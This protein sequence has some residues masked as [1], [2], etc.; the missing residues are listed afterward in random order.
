MTKKYGDY[1]AGPQEA[2]PLVWEHLAEPEQ[3]LLENVHA[4]LN[5]ICD[6]APPQ[7]DPRSPEPWAEIDQDPRG[8]VMFINGGR[9][10]GKTTLLVTLLD[11]LSRARQKNGEQDPVT[12]G[13]A[14]RVRPL[15]ILDFDPLPEGLPLHAWLVQAWLPLVKYLEGCTRKKSPQARD[16]ICLEAAILQEE[17]DKLFE[18]AVFGWAD[19]HDGRPVVERLFDHRDQLSGYQALADDW[20]VFVD[21]VFERLVKAGDP[22][23]AVILVPIDDVDLQVG[24]NTELIHATRLLRH[25]RVVYLIT[26]DLEHTRDVVLLDYRRQHRKVAGL[27]GSSGMPPEDQLLLGKC[28]DLADALMEKAFPET[29]VFA[30]APVSIETLLTLNG[31]E[32]Q[33]V[34]DELT[35]GDQPVGQW[36]LSRSTVKTGSNEAFMQWRGVQRMFDRLLQIDSTKEK[37]AYVLK[38]ILAQGDAA[39]SVTTISDQPHGA[40]VDFGLAGELRVSGVPGWHAGIRNQRIVV[41][42]KLKTPTQFVTLDNR[43]FNAPF[44]LLARELHE[45]TEDPDTG[46]QK[47]GTGGRGPVRADRTVPIIGAVLAWTRWTNAPR[48]AIFLWRFARY[49]SI[50]LLRRWLRDWDD[51]TDKIRGKEEQDEKLAY[52]W[53]YCQL[54]WRKPNV[55]PDHDRVDEPN[56]PDWAGKLDDAAWH[57]LLKTA[58]DAAEGENNKDFTYWYR[59]EL[60]L[61]ATP[62]LGLPEAVQ[63]RILNTLV[64]GAFVNASTNAE[65]RSWIASFDPSPVKRSGGLLRGERH[66]C[67]MNALYAEWDENRD[68]DEPTDEEGDRLLE[69]VRNLHPEAP[70]YTM[71]SPVKRK[72][73]P[74][75]P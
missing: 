8:R 42:T 36:L 46:A 21:H 49:P 29:N 3:K 20:R 59:R 27:S 9:G 58:A 31:G 10:S 54:R 68:G 4:R 35:V 25:P 39:K 13:L 38:E 11:Q 24:R 40:V 7:P 23:A 74:K 22:N 56:E 30:T 33:K 18:R 64:Q 41:G 17:W 26:G 43:S 6:R 28:S 1:G 52:A 12:G 61:F 73:S 71:R 65:F 66:Q 2:R 44:A 45:E 57:A 48:N 50:P 60:P 19:I 63:R 62:E 67:A 72:G 69:E 15:S 37:A 55:P 75:A 16:E 51:I 5:E 32:L 14:N 34:L 47:Q 70:W 53:V